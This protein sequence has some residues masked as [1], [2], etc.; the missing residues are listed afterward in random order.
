MLKALASLK[1]PVDAFFDGV[2]VMTEDAKLRANRVA[3]DDGSRHGV[4]GG[5]FSERD[6][7]PLIHP[8]RFSDGP[9]PG[10][11]RSRS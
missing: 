4:V 10:A 2:M 3:L 7:R 1:T 11:R 8:A 6:H 9:R 5:G